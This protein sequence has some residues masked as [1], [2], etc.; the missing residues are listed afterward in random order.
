VTHGD[1][2]WVAAVF[3][4]LRAAVVGI[5]FVAVI[6]V[7]EKALRNP[8]AIGIAAG[9]FVALFFV[10]VPFPLVIASAALLGFVS[11]R[12][13][14]GLFASDSEPS[15]GNPDDIVIADDHET[16]VAQPGKRSVKVLLLGL[17]AWWVPLL[18]VVLVF[19]LDHT[20]S[21]EALFFSQT[22]LI[23]FGGAYAVLSYI[24]QAA[25]QHFGWLAPGQMVTG[26]GLAESTP[27]PLIMVTEFVGFVAAYRFPGELDP[28][29]AGVLGA[30][31][32]TWATFAPCFLW[33]FLG[34]PYIERL[35]EKRSF[36][37]ALASITAAVVGII[38]NLGVVFGITVLFDE[39]EVGD[40]LG[41]TFPVPRL[42][43]IDLFALGVATVTFV[44]LWRYRWKV[45]WLVA[46]GGLA[47]LIYRTVL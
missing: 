15:D 13:R 39:V 36:N 28:V 5:V 38:L 34:A 11:E 10:K 32:T 14:P 8:V 29:V 18:L 7:G 42:G 41:V 40:F 27:G 19:G 44:G 16:T 33:I 1:V 24:N 6:R 4:G 12:I 43:S 47:G 37:A 20:L 25:V 46:F 22:A 26:L 31:V 23:T 21:K 3:Y 45:P 30:I 35:R 17:G 2:G 9:S